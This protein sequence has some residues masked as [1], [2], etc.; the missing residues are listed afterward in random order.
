MKGP[1]GLSVQLS[2]PFSGAFYISKQ[3]PEAKV[4][5][6]LDFFE[7]TTTME[8]TDYNYYGIENVD[9]TM[10]DGQQQLTEL[11]KKQ[12]TANG[13]GAIFPLAYNNKMK[14]VN[15]AA[16]KSYNDAKEKSV[17]AYAQAGKIDPFS[18][19]NSNTWTSIW[20]KYQAEWQSMVVKAI[21]GQISMD[22]YKAYVDK[23]NGSSDFQ[24]AYKEF[25]VD[26]QE[27]FPK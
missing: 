11:G 15:P 9:Y 27:K 23:L 12:V 2:V 24:K 16:P 25:A 17:A 26:Y 8:Q 7:R 14:V 10:V 4:K 18:I 19:I 20:P 22:E 3:V 13:T 5:Q 1:G 6:I 21:V